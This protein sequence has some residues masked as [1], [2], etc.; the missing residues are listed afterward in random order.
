[1]SEAEK[2]AKLVEF[3]LRSIEIDHD[4][5]ISDV[6]Q[7]QISENFGGLTLWLDN[8]QFQLS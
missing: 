2:I 6:S 8:N 1:M 4:I 5:K 7:V 3:V